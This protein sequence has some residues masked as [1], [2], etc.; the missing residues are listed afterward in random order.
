MVASRSPVSSSSAS[1]SLTAKQEVCTFLPIT[2]SLLPFEA[3]SPSA[4]AAA[5]ITSAGGSISIGSGSAAA[6]PF[7]FME[8][9][10]SA[11]PLPTL[12][13]ILVAAGNL[14]KALRRF[15]GEAGR[16]RAAGERSRRGWEGFAGPNL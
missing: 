16:G 1:G 8:A 7:P 15:G 6:F 2:I 14:A 4:A 10:R 11:S 3:A 12:P 5:A 13:T 9:P